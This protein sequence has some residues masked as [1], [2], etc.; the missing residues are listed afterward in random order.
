MK[1]IVI[2]PEFHKVMTADIDEDFERN[3]EE[4]A[5][6][7]AVVITQKETLLQLVIDFITM[8]KEMLT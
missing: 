2:F 8:V 7:A 1:M 3:V 5:S 6:I 4:D